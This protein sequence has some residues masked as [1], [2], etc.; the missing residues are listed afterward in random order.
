ME[1]CNFEIEI[2]I[3]LSS[4]KNL[5]IFISKQKESAK[6]IEAISDLLP[7]FLPNIE[8]DKSSDVYYILTGQNDPGKFAVLYTVIEGIADLFL[9]FDN[10][11]NFY[12]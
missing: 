10:T 2:K 9:D 12:T 6:I 4:R 5:E 7:A 3:K 8:I 1:F 11:P